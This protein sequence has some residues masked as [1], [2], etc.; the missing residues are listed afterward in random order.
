M[1][2]HHVT[3]LLAGLGLLAT[4]PLA[5]AAEP[6]KYQTI[7][8]KT[9]QCDETS[10]R[11]DSDGN[12]QPKIKFHVTIEGPKHVRIDASGIDDP[13][14]AFYVYSG[15]K[16]YEYIGSDSSY[17]IFDGPTDS[18]SASA[19]RNLS[20]VDFILKSDLND[21]V[22][23]GVKR[24]ITKVTVDGMPMILR[25]DSRGPSKDKEGVDT[26]YE[27]CLWYHADTLL[28]YKRTGFM[29]QG[30]K[31]TPTLGVEYTNYVLNKPVAAT[32]FVWA[33]PAGAK[34][35]VMHTPPAPLA[36][37]VTAP[38]FT[39]ISPDGKQVKLSDFKG[40]PV[41]LDFWATWCGPCQAA[42]PHLEKIYQ[43]VKTKDV[44]ILAVCVWD[45]KPDYE[46]WVTKNIGSKYNFPVAFDPAGTTDGASIAGKLYQV[47]GIPTQFV[48]DKDGKIA[49]VSVGYDESKHVLEDALGKLGVT[50]AMA[51]APAI[52]VAA[53]P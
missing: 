21:K 38:D 28:P 12:L 35:F 7:S 39:A 20:C 45:K 15:A 43:Q 26:I 10:F 3:A 31:R 34:E 33:P 14:P 49:A 8:A 29:V 37:G 42:M 53:K 9:I 6:E 41:I 44:V 32:K 40:K 17:R 4:V 27:D 47:S 13:K 22:D 51:D 2:N 25:T 46:K 24:T 16:E 48:I 52:T 5:H 50:V 18:G 11:A 19:I 36:A 30:D 23:D 1:S